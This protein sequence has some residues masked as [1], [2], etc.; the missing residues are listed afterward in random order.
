MQVPSAI[1]YLE[2]SK[3]DVEIIYQVKETYM[4]LKYIIS[5]CGFD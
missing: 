2:L 1:H 4:Q 5:C 3:I